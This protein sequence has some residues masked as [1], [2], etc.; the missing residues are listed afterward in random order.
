MVGSA[1]VLPAAT[2]F[3]SPVHFTL[4]R[5]IPSIWA[6][7]TQFR[8]RHWVTIPL[9]PG[10]QFLCGDGERWGL[11][12]DP[13]RRRNIHP[14]VTLQELA[15]RKAAG[16]GGLR[17]S[18]SR[19]LSAYTFGMLGGCPLKEIQAIVVV[20]H[21]GDDEHIAQETAYSLRF[22]LAVPSRRRRRLG[23]ASYT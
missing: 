13:I 17:G 11:L 20:S 3:G 23:K 16:R 22:Y 2:D 6:S 15:W 5:R 18:G 19:L 8:A 7:A 10:K 14:L 9:L 21:G 12:P 1:S 4:R